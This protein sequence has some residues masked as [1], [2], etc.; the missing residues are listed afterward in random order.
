MYYR[1]RDHLHDAFGLLVKIDDFRD[2]NEE[3]Q[4]EEED[5]MQE[6]K[7]IISNRKKVEKDFEKSDLKNRQV[8]VIEK[9][10][11]IRI[12]SYLKKSKDKIYKI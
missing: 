12:F 6:S 7:K 9:K 4:Q 2:N 5:G 11:L 8:L 10:S 1:Y 3:R